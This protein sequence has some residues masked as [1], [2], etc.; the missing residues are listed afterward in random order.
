MKRVIRQCLGAGLLACCALLSACGGGG[1]SGGWA[2]RALVRGPCDTRYTAAAFHF[3]AP[4]DLGRQGGLSG[5]DGQYDNNDFIVFID[6]FFA[7]DPAADLGQQGGLLGPDGLY[8]NN[9]FI[10]FI[11]LFFQACG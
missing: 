3:V 1:G 5:G 6:K 11:N 4:A 7:G 2:V 9:D 10:L 8:D